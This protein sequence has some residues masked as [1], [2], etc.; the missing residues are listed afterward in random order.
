MKILYFALLLILLT[1]NITFSQCVIDAGENRN[2]C[3]EE[4]NDSPQLF[5][6]VLSGDVS[7][8]EWAS[9]YYFPALNKTYFASDMLSDTTSLQPIINEHYEKTVTYYLTG[10]TSNGQT[11]KDSVTINFSDWLFVTIDKIIGKKPQDSITLWIAAQSSWGHLSYAWSPNFMISDTTIENPIV[12]ND[13]T[14]FYH[15]TITDSLNCSVEDDIFEVYTTTSSS[16]DIRNED[17]NIYP[18]PTIDILTFESNYPI[19]E[20]E[21]FH[22][23]GQKVMTSKHNIVDISDLIQ[24]IY[25]AKIL[26]DNQQTVTKL[27]VKK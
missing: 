26:F 4:I 27:I 21:I 8:V 10:I 7:Q 22:L 20:I 11:C 2:L 3:L 17:L 5:G 19:L 12:W 1:S 25:T 14:T 15:L 24:G 18:N 9:S 23:N 16:Q 13:T 6:T